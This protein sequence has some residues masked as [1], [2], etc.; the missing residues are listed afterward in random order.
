MKLRTGA[1]LA[2]LTILLLTA[3]GGSPAP[4]TSADA[5]PTGSASAGYRMADV[6][7]HNTQQDC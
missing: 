5:T 7:K 2:P 6:A 3:C 1:L 4:S